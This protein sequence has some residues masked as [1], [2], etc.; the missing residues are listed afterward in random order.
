MPTYF[1]IALMGLPLL[2]TLIGLLLTKTTRSY[3]V[4]WAARPLA[5]ALTVI[6]AW[7]VHGAT[8]EIAL[9]NWGPVSVTGAPL[10]LA[11]SPSAGVILIAV[12]IVQ[13]AGA[14][15]PR[16]V[17]VRAHH[18]TI[19][20]LFSAL[21]LTA[22]SNTLLTLIIGIGLV[23]ILSIVTGIQRGRESQRVMADA[24]FQGAS[25]ALLVVGLALHV[26]VGNSA[27]IP[28]SNVSERLMGFMS[29]ALALR[30]GLAPLRAIAGQ[31][32]DAH[33]TSQAPAI[34]GLI[35]L[36]KLPTLDAPQP[37]LWF[38]G[39][40]L[41]TGTL[42][43]FIGGITQ[44]RSLL[45]A[46]LCSSALSLAICAATLQEAGSVALAT[47]NWLA[48]CQL[49]A[50]VPSDVSTFGQRAALVGRIGGALSLIG[51]PL[52][53][54][55]IGR[56][57]IAASWVDHNEIG[58]ILL[59][60]LALVQVLL[61]LGALRLAFAPTSATPY[62]APLASIGAMKLSLGLPILAT[63]T[64]GA[65]ILAFGIAPGLASAPDLITALNRNTP[66]GWAIWLGP[67]LI[68]A[69][70]WWFEARWSR[71]FARHRQHL[72][73]VIGFSWLHTVLDGAVRRLGWPLSRVFPLLEGSSA[74]LWTV[75][76]VLILVLVARPGS[77]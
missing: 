9:G 66:A 62:P 55:F 22:L 43:G 7:V 69:L 57:G 44:R 65:H 10:I 24:M 23:D 52:T 42:S 3:S 38:F 34:S 1:V 67:T 51:L 70:L 40:A 48:G 32:H 73:N 33:W 11:S 30:F 63:V 21:A 59:I 6:V 27:Y 12:A 41:L 17:G 49:A 16:E 61:T 68:G 75:V 31:F 76:I 53:A 45:R 4:A 71:F 13:L 19:A 47:L 37:P 26:A 46:A 2:G 56:A 28:M 54:G 74:L 60:G 77:P 35:V 36:A 25:S 50:T 72:Y 39:L 64:L 14:L 15:H 18:I 5:A 20:L 8:F 58:I 29:V